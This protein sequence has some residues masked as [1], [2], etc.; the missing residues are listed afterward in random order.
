MK[1]K[2]NWR[3]LAAAAALAIA[4]AGCAGQ[5]T[6]Y[7]S[8]A[9]APSGDAAPLRSGGSS[10]SNNPPLYIE[11]APV[12]VPERLARAQM[13]VRKADTPPAQVEVLEAHRWS[14]SF[15]SEMRDA[16]AARIARQLGAIDASKSARPAGQAVW[17]IAVQVRQF[18]A[19]Q[20]SRVDADVS[21]I[22]YASE[23][24]ERHACALHATEPVGDS[25]DAVA[26]GAQQVAAMLGDAVAQHIAALQ[27]NPAAGCPQP[28]AG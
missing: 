22:V 18:D 19:V 28:V 5:P 9:Q 13:V 23:K 21:W 1:N 3:A 11:L 8:L 24:P 6:T 25:L 27:R 4:L 16:L 10:G 26:A 17:R 20:G 14:S 7:Y 12:A 2:T 15:D